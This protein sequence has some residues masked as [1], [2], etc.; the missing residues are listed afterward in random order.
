MSN[1]IPFVT[2]VPNLGLVE[3][4]E[5][6]DKTCKRVIGG[7]PLINKENMCVC[8]VPPDKEGWENTVERI[9]AT[10]L[11]NYDPEYNQQ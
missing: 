8:F 5:Q 6:C 4:Q 2:M 10:M 11:S 9:R 7:V 1:Q 3:S